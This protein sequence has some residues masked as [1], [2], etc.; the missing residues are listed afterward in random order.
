MGIYTRP[1]STFYWLLLERPNGLRPLREPT[2][3]PANGA[4]AIQRKLLREQAQETYTLRMVELART[5]YELPS[6]TSGTIR[7]AEYSAWWETHHLPKRRGAVR[8]RGCVMHLRAFFGADDLPAITP[9]RVTEYETKRLTDRIGPPT[10]S[11]EDRRRTVKPSTVNREVDVL[12][13]MLRD[14]APRW[15]KISPLAGRRKLRTVKI[16]KRVLS[17]EEEARLLSAL[18]PADQAF[19]IVAVDTLMRFSNV[20]NLKRTDDHK[21]HLVLEDSKTGP[22][23]VPLSSRA[24]A[25][26]DSLT[27]KGE[28]YFWHRHGAKNIH[29][30]RTAFRHLLERACRRAGIPYGRNNLG[31]TFHTAT[32]ATGATRL[33]RK[34]V[35]LKTLMEIGNWSDVRSA[36][37][38]DV[39]DHQQKQRA[40]NLIGGS[41]ITLQSRKRKAQ[42]KRQ[43]TSA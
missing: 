35:D 5:D 29:N 11:G 28:Y 1:D 19:Y 30:A 36:I 15:L 13:A 33:L 31:V 34:K 26:L 41:G 7:F 25:A 37:E 12:K 4:T 9:P 24:R 39:T 18:P 22:Y 32:R 21:T 14:A 43:R 38:Y 16:K 42:R 27:K 10:P 8:D 2:K 20:Y 17:Q 23:E 3:I 6:R 40:V